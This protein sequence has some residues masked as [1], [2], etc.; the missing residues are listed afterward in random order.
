MNRMTEIEALTEGLTVIE[1]FA[2]PATTPADRA[3]FGARLADE[4]AA[5]VDTLMGDPELSHRQ[6][7]A[8]DVVLQGL[9]ALHVECDELAEEFRQVEGFAG[10]LGV[11]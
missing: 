3:E 2:M 9:G 8:L 7:S 10:L 6:R 4:L 1:T 11:A 5:A